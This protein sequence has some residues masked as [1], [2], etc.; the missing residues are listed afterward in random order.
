MEPIVLQEKEKLIKRI[1]ESKSKAKVAKIEAAFNMAYEAHKPQ[2]RASGEPYILHPLAVAD[3]LLDLNIDTAS[4]I[5]ALLHDTVEDTHV[6]IEDIE[7]T[8]GKE[9]A[10]LVDGVTK[11]NKIEN[12]PENVKQAENFR[13]LLLA[14]SKDIRVLLVKLADRVHNMRTLSY[15]G[16]DDKRL[17]IAH[18][19]MEIYAPLAERIGIHKFK[20]ELQDLAFAELH[21]DMRKSIL[22]RLTFLRK[23][24]CSLVDTIVNEIT[25]ILAQSGIKAEVHGREKTSCSI[26]RKMERKNVTFEQLSDIIAFRIL[27]DNIEDCYHALGVMHSKYHVIPGTF[28]DYISTPK[29]NGYQSLHTVVMG[30]ERR[31]IEIQIRTYEMH[32]V[33]ELGFAAHWSYK[34]NNPYGHEGTQFRWVRELLDIL[35]NAS[36]PEEFMENTKLEM[37]YDQVF[38]FTPKG[39]LIA[40]P[41]GATPIDF[42]FAVHSN[43]GL[44]CIGARVNGRIVPLKTELENGDQVDILRSKVPMPSPTWE[45]IVITGKARAEIRKFIRSKQREEYINLGRAILTKTFEQAGKEYKEKDLEPICEQFQCKTVE[46][47][48]VSVG[49]GILNRLEV[50]RAIHPEEKP[51][52]KSLNPLS[53]LRFKPKKEEASQSLPIKGLIPGMAVHFAG[54]C[55]PLPGDRIVGIVNTG[56]GITIHTL[57]CE[58]LENFSSIPERWIDVGWEGTGNEAYVGR[59]KVVVANETGGLA[60]VTSCIAAQEVNITNI[61][62]V[63]RSLDF[64]ELLIDIEIKGTQQLVSLITAVRALNCVH[65]VDRTKS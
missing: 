56:K 36:S 32:E 20:N 29:A 41:K 39:D 12:Q 5:T 50:L 45:K 25:A 46:D 11:L 14:I 60:A 3:I 37:Y 52:R 49:D 61:K 38:C 33:A 2:F 35:E 59:I 43:V 7:K 6:T 31:C 30:P 24:G 16:S 23:E 57:D 48:L 58:M 34:Q 18:E 28:K 54:C 22:S 47:I 65:S 55:H 9:V 51:A 8:F 21:P 19:T 63:G 1:A 15:M 42:A 26:W 44:S 40:L 10:K 27:I 17:R 64:F 62:V 53:L 4:I 13:K